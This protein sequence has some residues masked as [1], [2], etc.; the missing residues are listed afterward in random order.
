MKTYNFTVEVES[1]HA[2]EN[3]L[4]NS[5]INTANDEQSQIKITEAINKK[6]TKIYNKILCDFVESI[7]REL[8]V[9]HIFG[10]Q[11]PYLWMQYSNEC[12]G[13]KAEAVING[14]VYSLL[15]IPEDNRDFNDSKYKTYTGDYHI[16]QQFW[17]KRSLN[18]IKVKT[19]DDVLKIMERDIIQTIKKQQS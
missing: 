4:I 8:N 10:F 12:Q 19:V 9:A 7:N 17:E 6:S 18:K 14:N 3:S 5:F 13:S 2:E 15:I 16:Q 11:E 1:V